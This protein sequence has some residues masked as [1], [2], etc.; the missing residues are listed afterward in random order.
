MAS[1]LDALREACV[2]ATFFVVEAF[3]R[4]DPA[5]LETLKRAVREGHE[6][7][8]HLVHD[9]SA[10][11]LTPAEFVRDLD[12]CERLICECDPTFASRRRKWFRPP[13]GYMNAHMRRTLRARGYVAALA[14]VFPLDTEV[15]SVDW[16]VTF[17]TA[18]AK[19][20]SIILVHA[21][22]V[23]ES[24]DSQPS[25]SSRTGGN[26]TSYLGGL[27]PATKSVVHKRQNNLEVLRELLPAL[28]DRDLSV[29]TLSDLRDAVEA[30][31]AAGL[32]AYALGASLDAAASSPSWGVVVGDDSAA[33]T[34][35]GPSSSSSSTRRPSS[36]RTHRATAPDDDLDDVLDGDGSRLPRGAASAPAATPARPPSLTTRVEASLL[37]LYHA[38][39]SDGTSS[40]RAGDPH[41]HHPKSS[42]AWPSTRSVVPRAFGGTSS[43]AWTGVWH[44]SSQSSGSAS[45]SSRQPQGADTVVSHHTAA[46]GVENVPAAADETADLR[47]AGASS[48]TLPPPPGGRRASS[49]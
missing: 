10:S 33:V 16:L 4:I 44:S 20:G 31:R 39:P 8:N 47:A 29:S 40:S 21:P 11:H 45:S 24:S 2:R 25:S 19:P 41:H 22:D 13:H 18:H 6:L 28:R 27:L 3:A 14:D 35:G 34:N 9:E 23:R 26:T 36:Q 43:S 7:G 17:V 48:E 37:R 32:A 1:L 15:R 12:Q 38:R 30:E 5:R 42:S 49:T 46:R